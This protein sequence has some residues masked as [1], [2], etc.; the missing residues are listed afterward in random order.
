MSEIVY[1]N[2]SLIPRSQAKVS[3]LDYGFLYGFGLF[4]TMRAYKGQ[5]FRLE[6]HLSR[7]ARSAELLRLPVGTAEL[8]DAVRDT[9]KANRLSDARIRITISAGEGEMP[10]TPRHAR[11]PQYWYWRNAISP[12]PKRSTRGVSERLSHPSAATA[13][14]PSPS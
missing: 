7:L 9:I 12:T 6:S 4:E 14:H 8:K 10:P 3:A 13:S 5:V 1:L 2:G 11:S